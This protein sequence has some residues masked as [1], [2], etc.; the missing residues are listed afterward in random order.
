[1]S[2]TDDAAGWVDVD[3]LP[4]MATEEGRDEWIE[5]LMAEDD[6]SIQEKG[7]WCKAIMVCDDDGN[8]VARFIY[9]NG[10]E[11]VFDLQVRRS[12]EVASSIEER[13]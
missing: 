7:G 4:D 13:N 10:E 1:M 12:I 2:Y 11:D 5:I 6:E 8:M 3:D 9:A